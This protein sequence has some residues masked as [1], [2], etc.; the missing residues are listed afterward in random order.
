METILLPSNSDA[1]VSFSCLTALAKTSCTMLNRSD[2]SEHLYLVP[3]LSGK[4]SNL[5][6]ECD[7][8]CSLL[9]YDLYY[10]DVHSFYT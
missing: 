3:D 10:V 7:V 4:A 8:S 6:V 2:K 9:I 5:T 1:F